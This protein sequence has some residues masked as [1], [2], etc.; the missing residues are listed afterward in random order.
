[1]GPK[2]V[3]VHLNHEARANALI[4]AATAL[5]RPTEA[6]VIGLYV[7]PPLFMPSDIV[8]PI[9]DDFFNAQVAEHEAQAGRIRAIFEQLTQGEPFVTEWRVHGDVRTAYDSIA[10]GV[11]AEARSAELVIV[12]QALS[13]IDAPMLTD[14]PASVTSESGRPTLI[15]PHGWE[16]RQFG[17]D[18]AI[19]WNDSR[20]AARA[21]FD[22]L[23][24]LARAKAVRLIT[25]GEPADGEGDE[26]ASAEV[27]ATLARHGI[28]VTVEIVSAGGQHLGKALIDK[29]KA[30][31]ADLLVM[32][33][34]GHSRMREFILGGATRDVLREMTV[35][36]L[37]S[38]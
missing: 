37:M 28:N 10:D 30:D 29:V 18:I 16:P 38:H 5:A 8:M 21:V 12:S 19:A 33:A 31:G 17:I 36:V 23:P 3:L 1:M 35:P 24:L 27:A 20:E 7:T 6:H 15:I 26:V 13:G 9:S 14:V 32:G 11:I 2:T 25:V 22:A 4:A 34:Y